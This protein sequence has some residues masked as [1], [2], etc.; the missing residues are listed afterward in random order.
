MSYEA[1]Y[2]KY[3]AKYLALKA[4]LRGEQFG[5]SK[6]LESKIETETVVGSVS[7][8]MDHLFRQLGGSRS[9]ST[10]KSSKKAKGSRRVRNPKSSSGKKFFD[11]SDIEDSSEDLEEKDD[12]SSSELDW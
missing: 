10:K 3:K 1:K 6:D 11:D 2:L 12:F 9:R 8:S 7:E 5:G 4:E